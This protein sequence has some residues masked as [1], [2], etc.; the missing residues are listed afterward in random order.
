MKFVNQ[1]ALLII[2]LDYF[3][4]LISDLLNHFQYANWV[5]CDSKDRALQNVNKN[6]ILLLWIVRDEQSIKHEATTLCAHIRID[7]VFN[8]RLR[9]N[10]SKWLH[11]TRHDKCRVFR[12]SRIEI[13]LQSSTTTFSS[14]EFDSMSDFISH[15][16]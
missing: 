16:E 10:D 8:D 2:L 4:N 14:F 3:F 1:V 13:C 9:D 6:W 7:N 5:I 12:F 11:L 15:S